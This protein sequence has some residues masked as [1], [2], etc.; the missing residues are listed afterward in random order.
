[1][2][3]IEMFCFSVILRV[4]QKNVLRENG[5]IFYSNELIIAYF[6]YP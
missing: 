6:I 4:S 3:P 2:N 5:H 1:M